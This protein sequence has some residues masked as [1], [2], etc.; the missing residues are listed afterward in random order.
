MKMYCKIRYRFQLLHIAV[1]SNPDGYE[2]EVPPPRFPPQNC[3]LLQ[4][5]AIKTP[6]W[7]ILHV[8][9]KN[10][11]RKGSIARNGTSKQSKRF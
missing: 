5:V 6:L 3:P 4:Q 9:T 1:Y 8:L 7:T 10:E 11:S 2:N